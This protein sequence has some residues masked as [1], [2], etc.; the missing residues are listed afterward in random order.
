[1]TLNPKDL[2]WLLARTVE[3]DGHLIWNGSCGQS[4]KKPRAFIDNK[5][6]S[7]RR[8]VWE[9]AHGR[10][11]RSDRRATSNCG[12]ENCVHPDHISA[13][14]PNA[15]SAGVPR[16]LADKMKIALARR[17]SSKLPEDAAR[18][19]RMGELGDKA[20]AERY[21]ISTDHAYAVRTGRCR[22]D[23]SSPFAALGAR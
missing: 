2:D 8:V 3:C 7:A 14:K 20:A 9:M 18:A 6:L 16:T 23:Y 5:N 19:L 22:P 13:D 17:V 10:V 15:H 21:G 11:L 12:V 4:G 1:M